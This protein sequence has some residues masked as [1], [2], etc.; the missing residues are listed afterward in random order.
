MVIAAA[1]PQHEPI[2]RNR[3][4]LLPRQRPRRTASK[5]GSIAD[6]GAVKFKRDAILAEGHHRGCADA[7]GQV[8]FQFSNGQAMTAR[9]LDV[10]FPKWRQLIPSDERGMRS[11]S[12]RTLPNLATR[13]GL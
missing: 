8:T 7:S 1:T 12:G 2:R 10:E 5:N 13:A 9:G 6:A 11:P 3:H 4:Q